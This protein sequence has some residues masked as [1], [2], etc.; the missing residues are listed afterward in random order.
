VLRLTYEEAVRAVRRAEQ[1]G[2]ITVGEHDRR[3]AQLAR[4]YLVRVEPTHD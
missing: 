4:L 1:D 2:Q 3:M